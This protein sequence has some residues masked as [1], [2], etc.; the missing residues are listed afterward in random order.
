MEPASPLPRAPR[1][2]VLA[3]VEQREIHLRFP[4]DPDLVE[5]VRRLPRRRW[6]PD[7]RIWRLPDTPEARKAVELAFGVVVVGPA[8]AAA[9]APAEAPASPGERLLDRLSEELRLRGYSPRTRKVYLGHVRR[10]LAWRAARTPRPS[11]EEARAYL[12]H[13]VEERRVSRSYH[14]QAVSA[15]KLLLGPVLAERQL[16]S[17]L[18]RPRVQ[19]PLPHVLSKQEVVRFLEELRHPKHRALVLLLYS[20]GLRVSE[21]VRLRPEDVDASQ[22]LLR[23]RQGKGAKDRY[24]LLSSRALEALRIYRE[25][26]RP[27]DWL[28]PGT[29]P[30]RHYTSRSVQRI[31]EQCARRAGITKKVTPHVLRHSFATHLLQSG[32]DL[33]YIQELLGHQSSRTTQ[34]YTH[35]AST[36]LARIRS[37]LDQLDDPTEPAR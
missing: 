35:V 26:F 4:W 7:R 29:R 36:E 27:T 31:V 22:G 8:E 5:K 24:T 28:F 11:V 25:A 17:E 19:R 20:S 33:R 18:P 16:A 30:G 13:L 3:T 10:F 2:P 21:V 14:S 6:D 9:E 37:P 32:T 12:V 34:I 15:L 1:R 23:V